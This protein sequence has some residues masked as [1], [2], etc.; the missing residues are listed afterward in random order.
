MGIE[1]PHKPRFSTPGCTIHLASGM[2]EQIDPLDIRETSLVND[3]ADYDDLQEEELIKSAFQVL[4]TRQRPLPK[5]YFFPISNKETKLEKLPP[6]S[7]KVC[8]SPKHWD[9]ECPYW[10]KYLEKLKNRSAWLA[11]LHL[12]KL[13][14][15]Q[16]AY[17]LTNNNDPS[18]EQS[19][20]IQKQDF[21]LAAPKDSSLPEKSAE[22]LTIERKTT[23]TSNF[24][25]ELS[26]PDSSSLSQIKVLPT[27]LKPQHISQQWHRDA[28]CSAI[29][30]S[31]LAVEGWIGN[32]H[33]T[34]VLLHHDSRADVSLLFWEYYQTLT[35]PPQIKKGAQMKLW[36][37]TD[38]D[39]DIE[40]YVTMP[41]F[42][43]TENGK[44]IET[45]VESYLVPDM[46]VPILLGK[47][48]QQNYELAVKRNL[49]NG[50]NP[51][52][53]VKATGVD[54]S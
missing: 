25:T 13:M 5:K 39:A 6:S 14:D 32:P 3:N 49:E 7:C 10:E 38:K 27:P 17:Q 41:I 36:Q 15:P 28:G 2:E 43:L 23:N 46:S 11:T 37:L 45:E 21:D 31:V 50:N 44:L 16:N 22:V 8:S 51:E 1:P 54:K 30:I 9:K 26:E 24:E 47:D 12:D 48:Y 42:T 33:N 34:P 53:M 18:G 4:K 20:N 29:G 35:N 19:D 52:L 40:G